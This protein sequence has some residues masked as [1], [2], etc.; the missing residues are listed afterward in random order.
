[1]QKASGGIMKFKVRPLKKATMKL[2][3]NVFQGK[4]VLK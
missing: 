4:V 2:E 3:K 1:M